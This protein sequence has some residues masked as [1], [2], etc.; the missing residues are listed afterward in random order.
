MNKTTGPPQAVGSTGPSEPPGA[1]GVD[2]TAAQFVKIAKAL[3]EPRRV[4]ILKQLGESHAPT[5][6]S[7]VTL[8]GEVSAPTVSHHL[9]ELENAGL[10]QISRQGKFAS[11]TLKRDVLN[12]YLN[13][14]HQI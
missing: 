13:L 6:C 9:K 4:R 5:P 14:L 7:A 11:L 10:L 3:A 1:S 12:A 8:N 2:L